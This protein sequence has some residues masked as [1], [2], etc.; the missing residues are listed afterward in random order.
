[1]T[2]SL[3]SFFPNWLLS[4]CRPPKWHFTQMPCSLNGIIQINSF[5][6]T[7]FPYYTFPK[8]NPFQISYIPNGLFPKWPLLQ[9]AFSPNDLQQLKFLFILLQ[10]FSLSVFCAISLGVSH[11]YGSLRIILFILHVKFQ[12]R[13]W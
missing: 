12:N 8:M 11:V 10:S 6:M 4:N 5:L 7:S 3:N 2:S 9:L 1:M 13:I